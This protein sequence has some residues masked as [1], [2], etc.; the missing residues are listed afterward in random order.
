MKES[1]SETFKTI[2]WK[3]VLRVIVVLLIMPLILFSAA[4]TLRWAMGW[5]YVIASF[6]FTGVSRM[7]AMRQS[8]DLLVERA[9]AF[10]AEDLRS[11]DR[12][13]FFLGALVGPLL[14]LGV[15]GLDK[16][17]SWSPPVQLPLQVIAVAVLLLGYVLTSWAFAVNRFFSAMVRIQKDRNHVVVTDGPYRFLRHPGYAGGILAMI[18]TPVML[19]SLWALL[20]AAYVVCMFIARTSLEDRTLQEELDGYKEYAQRIR[21]R[22]VPGLW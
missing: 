17:F 5:V 6:I 12:V 10:D 19:G 22:L 18:A 7:L 20:P 3:A 11:W 16:R 21:F 15:A 4:G 8:P 9:R 13:F 14:V 2:G 1:G